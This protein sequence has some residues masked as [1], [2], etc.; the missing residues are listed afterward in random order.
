MRKF[1]G[2]MSAVMAGACVLVTLL[3]GSGWTADERAKVEGSVELAFNSKYLWRGQNLV[4]GAVLQPGGSLSYGGVSG[5]VWANYDADDGEEWTELDYTLD[6]TTSLGIL[7]SGLDLVTLSVGYTHYTFPNLEAGDFSQEVYLAAA[8][9][10]VL[11]PSLAVYYDFEEGDGMYYELG[12][13]HSIALGGAAG[14]SLGGTVGYN[15]GEWGYESSFSAAVLSVGVDVPVA[16]GL[17]AGAVAGVSL[18]LDSQYENE[19]FGGIRAA[20]TF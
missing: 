17:T 2:K 16:K 11:P 13:G 10:T 6:Y 8:L 15:D 20:F 9:E 19:F 14:L 1:E 12:I 18:A 3:C 4:D 7:D 5:T